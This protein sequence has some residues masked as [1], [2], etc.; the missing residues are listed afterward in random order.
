MGFL[1]PHYDQAVGWDRNDGK[2]YG[3][4][5]NQ[6][7]PKLAWQRQEDGSMRF[8]FMRSFEEMLADFAQHQPQLVANGRRIP[9]D[10]TIYYLRKKAL[11]QPI[12]KEELAWLLL[13]FNQKR[14]YYQLRGEEQE[15][16]PTKKKEYHK[17]KV[18]SVEGT[19]EK[20]GGGT[21]Y[22]VH[23]ENG[24]IC[25]KSSKVPLY[26]WIGKTK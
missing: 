19:D 3:K 17:L 8:L 12:E 9:L 14:G 21:W 22:N 4:F 6:A 26:D 2:T 20:K 15:E 25:R 1:P 18:V 10:W 23:L 11:T 16:T 5:L 24:W 7:W 13:H